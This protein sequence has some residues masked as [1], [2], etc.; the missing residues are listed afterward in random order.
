MCSSDLTRSATD[1]TPS[2]LDTNHVLVLKRTCAMPAKSL[3]GSYGKFAYGAG[4]ITKLGAA[5]SHMCPSSA[6]LA[7]RAAVMMP[8]ALGWL[9]TT[10]GLPHS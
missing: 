4:M 6:A 7:T 8:P 5:Y 3:R 9:S 2:E 10:T 1:F